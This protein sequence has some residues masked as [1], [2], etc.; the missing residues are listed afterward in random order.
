MGYTRGLQWDYNSIRGVCFL[1]V[2]LWQAWLLRVLLWQA[3]LLRVLL[4]QR[5]WVLLMG[6]LYQCHW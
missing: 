4:Y 5:H 2:L 3:W 6:L 1:R